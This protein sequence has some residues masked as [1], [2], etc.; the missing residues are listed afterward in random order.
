M[1]KLKVYGPGVSVCKDLQYQIFLC[2]SHV[3]TSFSISFLAV[4]S[5]AFSS[6]TK[7]ILHKMILDF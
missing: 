7:G 1:M 6:L 4:M 2:G 5:T 3:P